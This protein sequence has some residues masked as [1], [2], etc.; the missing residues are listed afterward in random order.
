MV[1]GGGW[2]ALCQI[3]SRK[4]G[5]PGTILY[6][7]DRARIVEGVLVITYLSLTHLITFIL[8]LRGGGGVYDSNRPDQVNSQSELVIYVR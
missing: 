2:T 7:G 3:T 5:R 8:Y 1:D 4:T 6:T